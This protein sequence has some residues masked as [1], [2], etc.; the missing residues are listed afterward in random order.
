[1]TQTKPSTVA[2]PGDVFAFFNEIG[3]IGQLSSS[4][5]AKTLPDNVHPSHFSILNHL[6]RLGDG[7]TPIRIAEA[8]QV[9]KMTMTHSLK[10]LTEK[11]FIDVRPNPDDA[12]GKLVFLT[13]MGR[14]FR[15]RAIADVTAE[16]QDLLTAEQV[17]L[18]A[19]LRP[20]LIAIRK[21]LDAN[22]R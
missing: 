18:M 19:E 13:E 15:D 12:R 8:M 7:K 2:D 11:G 17:A 6:V 3:I 21:H 9:T 20:S 14:A 10:V 16:F 22:R 4:L 5:F 1:M